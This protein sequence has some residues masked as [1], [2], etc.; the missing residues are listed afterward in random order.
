MI[1]KK[2]I[3]V[4]DF[5]EVAKTKLDPAAWGYFDAGSDSCSTRDRNESAFSHVKLR[6]RVLQGR[7]IERFDMSTE[8]FGKKISSPICIGPAAMQGLAH[9]DAEVAVMKV[10]QKRGNAYGLSTLSNVEL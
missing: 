6:Q 1:N 8:I 3:S 5:R 2:L 10:A 4:Q 7:L 9:P